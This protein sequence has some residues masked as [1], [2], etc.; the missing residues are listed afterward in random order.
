MDKCPE[1]RV[2]E[3]VDVYCTCTYM[4]TF[5]YQCPEDRVVEVDDVYCTYMYTFLYKCPEDRVVD[6]YVH[7]CIPFCTSVQ[8]TV[9]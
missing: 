9:L 7:T 3:V 8:K 5:L 1:D 6:V 4:Y 2:V